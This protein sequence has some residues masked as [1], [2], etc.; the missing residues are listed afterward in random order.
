[1]AASAAVAA[2]S[3]YDRPHRQDPVRLVDSEAPLASDE[4]LATLEDRY[5]AK[6]GFHGLNLHTGRM[7]DYRAD[8]LFATCSAFKA[9]VA[10]AI[11][12]KDQRGEL[13][14]NDPV[15]IDPAVLVPVASTITEPHVGGYL[16]LSALC[17]ASV[18]QS[19]NTATNLMVAMLG[20]PGAVTEFARSTGDDR[21][22][23]VRWELE[24]NSAYPGD[25]RDTSTP[26][27]MGAGFSNMLTGDVFDD[28]HRAQLWEW[29]STIT[30]GNNRIRAGLPPEWGVADK[31][32]AG[33]YASTNDI[34]VAFGPSGERLILSIM[35]RTRSEDPKTPALN[36]LIADITRL[37]V[38]ALLV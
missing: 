35:T 12:A 34:G 5:N 9:Y 37:A 28:A 10:G 16:P 33:D 19:D 24:L 22:W 1:M 29:M 25:P 20:G 32:G 23:M 7:L 21:I 14:L 31:T 38:P 4:Q 27:S 26:R 17:A 3:A 15:F 36:A 30:T 13:S 6:V 18:R 2:L 11:L 8:D